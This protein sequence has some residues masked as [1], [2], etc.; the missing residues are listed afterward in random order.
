MKMFIIH[1][2]KVNL[3]NLLEQFF[4]NLKATDM[5]IFLLFCE[6]IIYVITK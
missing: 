1:I 5:L 3:N 2:Y 6:N 4:I